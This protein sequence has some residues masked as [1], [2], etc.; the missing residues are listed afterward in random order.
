MNEPVL[1]KVE[2]LDTY[3]K[4]GWFTL[5]DPPPEHH[6]IPFTVGWLL[7]GLSEGYVCLASTTYTNSDGDLVFN[8]LSYIPEVCVVDIVE[9]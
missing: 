2:W 1:V 3:S 4:S 6:V 5:A 9:L 8:D 7:E